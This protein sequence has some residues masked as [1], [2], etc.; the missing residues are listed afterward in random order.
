M[1][2]KDKLEFGPHLGSD[3]TRKKDMTLC[4]L[5]RSMMSQASLLVC[6]FASAGLEMSLPLLT[7]QQ[8]LVMTAYQ[9]GLYSSLDQT[10]VHHPWIREFFEKCKGCESYDP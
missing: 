7:G 4:G 9:I 2:S 5:N 10:Q 8:W 1:E 3:Q 6:A